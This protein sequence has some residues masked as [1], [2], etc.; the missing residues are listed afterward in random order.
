M[1]TLSQYTFVP[2]PINNSMV[3]ASEVQPT[4][5]DGYL[6]YDVVECAQGPAPASVTN[7]YANLN[8]YQSGGGAGKRVGVIAYDYVN[9][10]WCFMSLVNGLALVNNGWLNDI[11]AIRDFCASLAAPTTI[12]QVGDTF[13]APASFADLNS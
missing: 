1:A 13:A 10:R 8:A 3:G 2:R 9:A 11:G 4:G 6:Y 5:S 12:D 7:I